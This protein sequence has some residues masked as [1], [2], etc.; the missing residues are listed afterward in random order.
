MNKQAPAVDKDSSSLGGQRFTHPAFGEISVTRGQGSGTE[1]F[2]SSLKHR[3][4][5]TVTISTAHLDRHLN[6]DWIHGDKQ[7]ASFNMSET[8]WASFVS[9]VGG[10]ATPITFE[11]RPVDSAELMQ[12]PAIESAESMRETF[13]R[14]VQEK[15]DEAM[16]KATELAAALQTALAEG[17]AG[18]NTLKDLHAMAQALSVGLPNTMAFIQKQTEVAME[19]TVAAGKVE[20]ESFVTDLATRTGIDMLREQSVNL[21][22]DK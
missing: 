14:E 2:G 4:V 5:I 21:L 19:K 11:M 18:K 7:V 3:N 15:C 22:N 6:R 9:S 20:I 8:Q 13:S 12:C 17:K 1:L 10:M 16:A